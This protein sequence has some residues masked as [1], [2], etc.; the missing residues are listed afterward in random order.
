MIERVRARHHAARAVPEHEHRQS[1]VARLRELDDGDE[2]GDVV[3][4]RLGEVV[5]ASRLA[6][7]A[8]VERVHGEVVLDEVLRSPFVESAVRH[9]TV[10][11]HDHAPRVRLRTPAAHEHLHTTIALDE[12]FPHAQQCGRAFRERNTLALE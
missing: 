1:R 4:R 6:V 2:V 10:H 5:L 9:E 12:F 3:F 11:D 7:T 8:E